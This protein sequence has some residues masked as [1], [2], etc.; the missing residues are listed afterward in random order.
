MVT[1]DR[2]AAS[3]TRKRRVL[4]LAAA[5]LLLLLASGY[6]AAYFASH[7]ME[8][9]TS[10]EAGPASAP[11]R[12]LIASQGSGFKDRLVADLVAGLAQH[13]LHVKVIDVSD[14]AD[15]NDVDWQVIVIVHT[16]EF[17]KPPRV[18]ADFLG[19]SRDR[20][21]IIGISTS[22]SGREKLAGVDFISSASVMEDAPALAAELD[23]R[24]LALLA[25]GSRRP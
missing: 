21:R 2:H 23:A 25:D 24:I 10:W 18:V 4:V 15:T 11:Q 8:E 7:A 1:T 22:G 20:R 17:G 19:R 14:L 9:I 12:V 5:A 16:W 13:Q 6:I 3:T